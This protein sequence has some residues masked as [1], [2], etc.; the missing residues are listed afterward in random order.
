MG[1]KSASEQLPEIPTSSTAAGKQ[2]KKPG[3]L[4][5]IGI[6]LIVLIGIAGVGTSINNHN[7]QVEY[8]NQTFTW[9]TSGLATLLPEPATNKGQI[10]SNSDE[11]LDIQVHG[12]DEES[13]SAYL[14][15]CQDAGFTMEASTSS[16]SYD[17]Y[18]EEGNKLLLSLYKSTDE[19]NIML[20]KAE[21]F[22]SLA[23]PTTGL[24][25]NLPAPVSNVG[26]VV[27]DSSSAW[28][29]TMGKTD[30][31]AY[32]AYVE[33]VFAAGFD[34]NYDKGDESFTA[35]NTDGL[36][37]EVRYTGANTMSVSI[38]V[39]E[40]EE[41]PNKGA[42]TTPT[43]VD[44]ASSTQDA[45]STVA[46][47]DTASDAQ[48]ANPT[49]QAGANAAEAKTASDGNAKTRS[50]TSNKKDDNL[51]QSLINAGGELLN[52]AVNAAA[53]AF[54]T[55]EFKEMLDSY[56]TFMNHYVEIAKQAETST[57]AQLLSEYGALLQEEADWLDKI[58]AI[59]PNTLSAADSAYYVAVTGR[60]LVKVSELPQ[61]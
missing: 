30:K 19:M 4:A 37:V 29:A 21:E 8:E 14:K 57:D 49:T 28:K 3:C 58:N 2:H 5:I 22:D 59:D 18:D 27:T 10:I 32:K 25:A 23:W 6:I 54:V 15:Q 34:Q 52:G 16:S 39:S 26:K 56:E 13:Y 44:T 33:K 53:D 48:D 17:A 45:G 36:H 20:N 24:A 1:K 9:P 12:C 35:D 43:A 55:P 38:K 42:S 46:T 50:N 61:R 40:S 31:D 41:Q 51:G 47:A 60:V 7:K 11:L